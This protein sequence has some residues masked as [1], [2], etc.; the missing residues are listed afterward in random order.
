MRRHHFTL[1]ELL[2]VIAIIAILAAMLLPALNRARESA[3][4][5]S[6]KGN[7]KQIGL[8][9]MMYLGDNEDFFATTHG[10]G[11]TAGGR[12]FT[13]TLAQYLGVTLEYGYSSFPFGAYHLQKKYPI[14][15]CPSHPL[16]G[17]VGVVRSRILYKPETTDACRYYVGTDGLSFVVSQYIGGNPGSTFGEKSSRIKNPSTKFLIM[18][19]QM[20][21]GGTLYQMTVISTSTGTARVGVRHSGYV[22]VTYADGH[23]GQHIGPTT[24]AAQAQWEKESNWSIDK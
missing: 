1:I 20:T 19:G 16:T 13:H 10:Q 6:C 4:A 8:A 7:L 9:Y 24:S 11:A 21:A 17:T 12:T 18:D 15:G 23:V 2:V 5:S 22:N 14:W 3:R